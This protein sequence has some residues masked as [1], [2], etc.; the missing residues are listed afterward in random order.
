MILLPRAAAKLMIP[1]VASGGMADAQ[2]LVA[3]PASA[4]AE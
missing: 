1:F 3:V 4:Q 2:S